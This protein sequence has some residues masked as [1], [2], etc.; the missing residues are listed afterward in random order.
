MRATF[1]VQPANRRALLT[2]A[3]AFA[4]VRADAPE[5]RLLHAWLDSWRGVGA[6]AVGMARQ[7]YDLQI[8]RYAE[9]GWRANFYPAGIAHSVV[10]GSGW[11]ST[12]WRAVQQ[13]AWEVLVRQ[14]DRAA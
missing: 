8:T 6:I 10:S 3:L 2:A 7:G 13:A 11:A 5:L 14:P 9:Q 4:R 12:P 1:L